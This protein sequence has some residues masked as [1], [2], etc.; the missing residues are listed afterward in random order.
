[1]PAA[2]RT[3]IKLRG[4]LPGGA[5]TD[6]LLP[7]HLDVPMDF[8]AVAKAGS[9]MGTGT[10][11]VLDDKTCPVQMVLNLEQFFAQES[12]GWCTPCRD[13]LPWTATLLKDIVEGHGRPEDLD[14]LSRLTRML[15][16][17]NTFCA[18]A[19]G[20]MEPLQSALKY[21]REDFERYIVPKNAIKEASEWFTSK[22]TAS[23]MTS[24]TAS[25]VL[26]ACLSLGL[27]L[28]YFC[29]HPAMGSVGACRQCAV[30]QYKD[31]EDKHGRLV[32]ACMTPVADN[33]RI[34]LN[35]EQARQFRR[36]NI[37]LLM[38]NHPHDCPVCEEGG[39][40][41]LQD[42][43]EMT[44]HTVRRYRGRK[45]THRNQDLGPFINHE[46]NRCIAC[47]RCVRFYHDYAGGK[48]LASPGHPQQRLFRPLRGWRAGE[49]IAPHVQDCG[50][51][52][53]AVRH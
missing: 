20:A 34:S 31:A 42:M 52:L 23:L 21:F 37:E 24:R 36:D 38:I 28:P 27:D 40:C 33:M 39:E 17:G 11:I 14:T 43:T 50:G 3:V 13:G 29:W 8:D 35:D 26:S 44:G 48:D 2:C 15:G 45:R 49:R 6:F 25:N 51:V 46:M 18:L 4:F 1:M 47:Y 12:C 16:P 53:R 41:H 10:I 9:R 22:S 30:I 7:E 19:P 32:M 5:S